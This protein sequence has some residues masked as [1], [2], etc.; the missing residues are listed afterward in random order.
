M[1]L[2]RPFLEHEWNFVIRV[3][4]F[5]GRRFTARQPYKKQHKLRRQLQGEQFNQAAMVYFCFFIS[6]TKNKQHQLTRPVI[7]YLEGR[8]IT[9]KKRRRRRQQIRT[10]AAHDQ[11]GGLKFRFLWTDLGFLKCCVI[12]SWI[13][14]SMLIWIFLNKICLLKLYA[15]N[16]SSNNYFF[17]ILRNPGQVKHASPKR[18]AIFTIEMLVGSFK[19]PPLNTHEPPKVASGW[20]SQKK[21][22]HSWALFLQGFS[23]PYRRCNFCG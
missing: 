8:K 3:Q 5:N 12:H 21:C 20:Q 7:R 19:L 22:K 1:A 2:S 13:L 15:F 18:N 10:E 6:F 11:R 4:E 17:K 16:S 9:S 14:V 23:P